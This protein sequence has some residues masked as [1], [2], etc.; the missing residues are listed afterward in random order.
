M[1]HKTKKALL[2]LQETMRRNAPLVR[3]KLARAK[4]ADEGLVLS[5]AMYLPALDKLSRQ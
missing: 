2:T 1:S 3:R 4:S 5:V